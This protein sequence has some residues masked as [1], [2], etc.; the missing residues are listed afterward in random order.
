V[1]KQEFY[2]LEIAAPLA[3]ELGA[4]AAHVMPCQL[5][6]THRARVLLNDLQH[7]TWREILTPDFA[8]LSHRAKDLS[9]GN[10]GRVRRCFHPGGD[11][12]RANPISLNEGQ[13]ARLQSLTEVFG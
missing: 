3:A 1:A 5:F 8:R 9:L 10:A 4:G 11:G 12:N 6:K 2:L 13:M 7:G